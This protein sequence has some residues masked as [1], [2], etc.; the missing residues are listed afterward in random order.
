MRHRP[1]QYQ[2]G[3]EPPDQIGIPDRPLPIPDLPDLPELPKKPIAG[4]EPPDDPT[5]LG[6]LAAILLLL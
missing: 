2:I 1:M 5:T 3:D 6:G 4:P